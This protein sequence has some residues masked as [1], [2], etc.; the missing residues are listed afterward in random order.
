MEELIQKAL[1][2]SNKVSQNSLI[3]KISPV[4]GGV[5]P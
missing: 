2:S 4:G 1:S 3:E 5:Y